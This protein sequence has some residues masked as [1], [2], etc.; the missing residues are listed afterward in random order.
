MKIVMAGSR[1]KETH[2]LQ[3]LLVGEIQVSEWCPGEV[4]MDMENNVE[5]LRSRRKE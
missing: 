4:T 3:L 1:R 5:N 2:T